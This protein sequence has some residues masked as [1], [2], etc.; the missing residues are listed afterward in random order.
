[1]NIA[2]SLLPYLFQALPDIVSAWNT[3]TSNV[4]FGQ[5]LQELAAPVSNLLT[6]IGS[7]LFPKAAPTL[8]LIAGAIGAFNPDYTKW[9][10]GSLNTLSP[11]L[12]LPNPNL[13]VDGI[14]GPL[15]R[16]AVEAVQAHF[17]IVVDGLAGN[18]TQGWIA[19]AL[20]ALPPVA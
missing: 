1:M 16:A 15:T 12:G 17:G 10:Q 7:Q 4:S 11:T 19:K 6:D 3:T 5:K 9:L 2:L 20:A 18:I 13:A 8:H 14:Y